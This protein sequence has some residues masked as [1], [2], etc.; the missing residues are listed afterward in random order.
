MRQALFQELE[1]SQL[2]K[3]PCPHWVLLTE[4]VLCSVI[5]AVEGRRSRLGRGLRITGCGRRIWIDLPENWSFEKRR[6]AGEGGS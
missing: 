3:D 5:N 2:V 6:G 4:Y 1:M